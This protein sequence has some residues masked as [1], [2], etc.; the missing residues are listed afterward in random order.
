M[1]ISWHRR[2]LAALCGNHPKKVQKSRKRCLSGD[3]YQPRV[4][5]LEERLAPAI[6][7]WT[8][9]AAGNP[10][11]SAGANWASGVAPSSGDALIFPTSA[12]QTLTNND[13]PSGTSFASLTFLGP[14]ATP[15]NT[16]I[17]AGYSI[18]GNSFT[19]V[20]G[21]STYSTSTQTVI[22]VP[23]IT[24]TASQT[25]L[26]ANV[27][28]PFSGN[29]N[30]L[31]G[32]APNQPASSL[33]IT[34]AVDV[35]S[36]TLTFDGQG[37]TYMD[38][39]ITGAGNVVKSGPGTA[40][41]GGYFNYTTNTSFQVNN[42]YTGTTTI[43]NGIVVANSGQ[44]LGT[45][46]AVTVNSGGTLAVTQNWAGIAKTINLNGAGFDGLGAIE[47]VQAYNVDI[48]ASV[49]INLASTSSISVDERS[50]NL[51][52]DGVISGSGGLT[53]VGHGTLFLRGVDTYTGPTVI[54]DTNGW[55]WLDNNGSILNT[56][57]ITIKNGG[58][59][60]NNTE[61]GP[62]Q[63][64]N[65]TAPITMS[66]GQIVNYAPSGGD[67]NLTLNVG[68]ITLTPGT[69]NA[70]NQYDNEN[71]LLL[72]NIASITPPAAGQT[73]AT[74]LFEHTDDGK[75]DVLGGP[76]TQIKIGN[77]AAL[78]NAN[79]LIPFASVMNQASWNAQQE[80]QAG[81]GATGV[82]ALAL[83]ANG[84]AG[85]DVSGTPSGEPVDS[86]FDN[87]NGTLTGVTSSSGLIISQY[88]N[89]NTLTNT[90]F[91]GPAI[92]DTSTAL[93]YRNPW[94]TNSWHESGGND[95]VTLNGVTTSANGFFL[96]GGQSNDTTYLGNS[97]GTDAVANA[98]TGPVTV[99]QGP[100]ILGKTAN[101]L[102]FTGGAGNPVNIGL[103]GFSG[104]QQSGPGYDFGR[105]SAYLEELNSG[106]FGAATPVNIGAD[107]QFQLDNGVSQ[108]IGLLT[109]MSDGN[110]AM[111]T[112]GSGAILTLAGGLTTNNAAY[113]LS[114]QEAFN[115][116]N[117]N[118][119]VN[120]N[121]N[122]VVGGDTNDNNRID[123]V[124]GSWIRSIY[125]NGINVGSLNLAAGN[126]TF[127]TNSS[128]FQY[129]LAVQTAIGGPG[130]L[131]KA[132]GGNM[133]ILGTAT[134]GGGTVVNAGELIVDGT[135]NGTIT[136]NGG[137]LGGT[138]GTVLFTS[139]QGAQPGLLGNVKVNAGGTVN[140]G[141][142][143]F[144]MTP[145]NKGILTA[146]TADFSSGGTLLLQ[147]S[148]TTTAGFDY[149]KFSVTG[150]LTLGGS[151]VLTLD[152]NGLG[153]AG[154]IG[155]F[156]SNAALTFG[157][158]TGM[159]SDLTATATPGM[160]QVNAANVKN[161][162]LGFQAFVVFNG[163]FMKIIIAR[164][165]VV[166]S[167]VFSTSF[168]AT[169]SQSTPGLLTGA[170]DPNPGQTVTAVTGTFTGSAGGKLTVSANG[171]FTYTPPNAT[172]T[173]ADVFSALVAQDNL[174]AT[175]TFKATF[176]DVGTQSITTP[177]GGTTVTVNGG[178]P[179]SQPAPGL[180]SGV[181][182]ANPG[183][184]PMMVAGTYT[185]S[186]SGTLVVAAN[187]S[188]TYTPPSKF[189][190]GT[191]AF[192]IPVIDAAGAKGTVQITFNDV[193]LPPPPP[194]THL[195]AT[196]ADAGAIPLVQVYDGN[197]NLK[198]TLAPFGPF[199][200][201]GIRVATGDVNG[202]GV[203]DII[204][205]AGPGGAPQV[206]VY[207][208]KTG[209]A[210]MT[211]LG[212]PVGFR[213]GV[214]VAAGDVNGDGFADIVVGAGA[215]AG[216]EVGVFSGKDGSQIGAFFAFPV[217]FRGGVHVAAGDVRGVGHADIITGAG[218]GG[219][220][221][222]TIYDFNGTALESFFSLN[223]FFAGGIW[224]GAGDLN[225][226]GIADVL[227]GAG[228]G[229][230]PQVQL[231][232]GKSFNILYNGYAPGYPPNF[233]G[234]VRVG[235]GFFGA[236]AFLVAAGPGGGPQVTGFDASTLNLL[237]SFFT[238]NPLF[239]GGVFVS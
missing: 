221:Q 101:T 97:S 222:L 192:S 209:V 185:G 75:G 152:L 215:G 88:N 106:Q 132:G 60:G 56:A 217:G 178:Q 3:P 124:V 98:I 61:S 12:A 126:Q 82:Q 11:W 120:F 74:L 45:T 79:G 37:V 33:T 24:L 144:T 87:V 134:P 162:P 146:G 123:A 145:S 231:Y 8:G 142:A 198:Y 19:V 235:I 233:T 154:I 54:D 135:L 220:P 155:T 150:A 95:T 196:G 2:S 38:G 50:Q 173:G 21:I 225:G 5:S 115:E 105:Q 44:A 212:M 218:P 138:G 4:E 109:M 143:D 187:G 174:G 70:I 91:T 111:V 80:Q 15:S 237:G 40:V 234:G 100:L 94:V 84:G 158:V 108:Q 47:K 52:L 131:V 32:P 194:P 166:P 112:L 205:A 53:K 16:S 42:T 57:S 117:P 96:T 76:N 110:S 89:T 77:A 133:L 195:F 208:G 35:G 85:Q 7:I 128:G 22:T 29:P 229:G 189:F 71:N 177:P 201:G 118:N 190:T 157:S 180:L 159:F 39:T 140:P 20:G 211:F 13:L 86:L 207:D 169:L 1:V 26:A 14:N 17:Q 136:V 62:P 141:W 72:L 121:I 219:A 238:F 107:G 23:F 122:G 116:T 170:T 156:A 59:L 137:V 139:T 9:A 6:Q 69:V 58:A 182:D 226:D 46:G 30:L 232:S 164:P 165:P 202:D 204:C 193:G 153:S 168:G 147:I 176:N 227:V 188:Y 161:N 43:N 51:S 49:S 130:T 206:V 197:G 90:T 113:P 203:D 36:N 102:A 210:Y 184:T 186:A 224:V 92:M 18:S 181:T 10:N 78:Q 200:S 68:A 171:S 99:G 228:A 239:S 55:L 216:P 103:S 214:F 34:S 213:G 127:T 230:G 64:F 104:F 223:P 81:Y 25:F 63:H 41:L 48:P 163:S 167:Q 83:V 191:D 28:P 67:P 73:V 125:N 179:V 65:P 93:W 119:S 149:D 27:V 114:T 151:S 129:D 183:Q 160:F 172:F 236:P 148:N 175:T 66:G 199:F 31:F